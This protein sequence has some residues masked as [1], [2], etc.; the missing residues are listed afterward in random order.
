MKCDT[1]IQR[2]LEA[3]PGELRGEGNA[4][5]AGHLTACDRCARIAETLAV[6]L[7][8]LDRGL[9]RVAQGGGDAEA[10]ADRA[11]AAVGAER[12]SGPF[13]EP[14]NWLRS[15][16]V[17]LAAAAALVGVLLTGRDPAPNDGVA[18]DPA[19]SPTAARV[20]VTPP[21]ERGVAVLETGNPK[22]TIIWLYER[23]E[24]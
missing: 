13:A 17:P 24:S 21:A 4:P 19:T 18:A 16:W 1:V 5:L 12:G 2:L 14:G 3:E 7:E 9:D 20:A 11:L 22:I 8:A 23:E 15:A 10:A 6:E